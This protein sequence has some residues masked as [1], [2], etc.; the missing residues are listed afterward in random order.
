MEAQS[1]E[2]LNGSGEITSLRKRWGCWGKWI[3]L[4]FIEVTVL[5]DLRQFLD[6]PWVLVSPSVKWDPF[7]WSCPAH[8][9]VEVIPRKNYIKGILKK[10][11][12]TTWSSEVQIPEKPSWLYKCLTQR[13][14][15]SSRVTVVIQH[16]QHGTQ[17][18]SPLPPSL[19]M[20]KAAQDMDFNVKSQEV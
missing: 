15:G 13:M 6:L 17:K 5:F 8:W 10:K 9:A 3:A 2:H 1:Q 19:W 7:A 16:H 18:S 12:M 11:E 14:K 4:G 20:S